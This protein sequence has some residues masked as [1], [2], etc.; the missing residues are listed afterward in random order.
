MACCHLT[1]V[2]SAAQA[3]CRTPV[4]KFRNLS[5]SQLQLGSAKALFNSTSI[6]SIVLSFTIKCFVFL[7]KRNENKKYKV[8]AYREVTRYQEALAPQLCSPAPHP[9]RHISFVLFVRLAK[10]HTDLEP[11][12][13]AKAKFLVH[14]QRFSS[15]YFVMIR[16]TEP[17][18]Q[19][20][21][22][23]IHIR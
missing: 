1:M 3:R 6:I 18:L 20:I 11:S 19:F 21:L 15:E 23:T 10:S 14:K 13:A 2:S 9:P 5:R 22:E 8:I 12:L 4:Q 7:E 17:I 16:K